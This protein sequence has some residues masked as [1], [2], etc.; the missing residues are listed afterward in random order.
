MVR[1]NK[2]QFPPKLPR[3]GFDYASCAPLFQDR[4]ADARAVARAMKKGDQDG[5]LQPA[6]ADKCLEEVFVA[7][8]EL[9]DHL[10][11]GGGT[12]LDKFWALVAERVGWGQVLPAVIVAAL[13][14]HLV[15]ARLRATIENGSASGVEVG[16]VAV[17]VD[18]YVDELRRRGLDRRLPKIDRVAAVADTT[19]VAVNP[20]AAALVTAADLVSPL[21][22]LT[23]K[24]K[25]EEDHEDQS[26][27]KQQKTK[28]GTT[29][30]SAAAQANPDWE[31]GEVEEDNGAP[32]RAAWEL[33]VALRIK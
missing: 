4:C 33:T 25:R 3:D 7:A 32:A 20:S 10:S 28:A 9:A 19:T 21:E 16:L 5:P 11:L 24:R 2:Y 8:R 27:A 30:P 23:L 29:D 13:A 18:N 22:R 17:A 14:N 1:T 12:T 26:P 6:I 15:E 31:N